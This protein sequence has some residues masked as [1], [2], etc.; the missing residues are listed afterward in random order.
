ML[1]ELTSL[2]IV[3]E[4]LAHEDLLIIT[5]NRYFLWTIGKTDDAILLILSH[6]VNSW[7]LTESGEGGRGTKLQISFIQ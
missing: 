4:V 3:F 6:A 5:N 2:D 1:K 7:S